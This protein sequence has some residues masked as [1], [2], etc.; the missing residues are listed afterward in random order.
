M[1]EELHK[2]GS[3]NLLPQGPCAIQWLSGQRRKEIPE[4]GKLPEMPI[5]FDQI[6][7]VQTI[8]KLDQFG[9]DQ[10]HQQMRVIEPAGMPPCMFILDQI[11]AP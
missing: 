1:D 2:K 10:N 9:V 11:P 3:A 5:Q 8:Y 6:T 4:E 7:T